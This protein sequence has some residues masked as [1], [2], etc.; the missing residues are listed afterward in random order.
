[1]PK[2]NQNT[3]RVNRRGCTSRSKWHARE[4]N[5]GVVFHN[6]TT[7]MGDR[8]TTRTWRPYSLS[9]GNTKHACY[10]CD[11][12]IPTLVPSDAINISIDARRHVPHHVLVFYLNQTQT[13]TESSKMSSVFTVNVVCVRLNLGK[14][15]WNMT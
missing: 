15:K 2:R 4:H 12:L 1:M 14:E 9:H 6:A 11:C 3:F 10:A 8:R 5:D 13:H 7:A